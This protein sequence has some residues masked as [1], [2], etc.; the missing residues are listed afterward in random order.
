MAC[1]FW[2]AMA[3]GMD[4]MLWHTVRCDGLMNCGKAMMDQDDRSQ[5]H[6]AVRPKHN[7]CEST[8]KKTTLTVEAIASK[9][10]AVCLTSCPP[11][12][13]YKSADRVPPLETFRGTNP[14]QNNTRANMKQN[15]SGNAILANVGDVSHP[16]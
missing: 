16:T 12:C 11:V 1:D 4:K 6:P 14:Y 8:N 5:W 3:C 9:V 15:E 10:S 2:T 13:P 7:Q